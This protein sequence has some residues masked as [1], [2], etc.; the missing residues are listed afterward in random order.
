MRF[1]MVA[2]MLTAVIGFAT[3][4]P[5]LAQKT[6]EDAVKGVVRAE[7]EAFYARN[8]EAWQGAWLHDPSVTRTLIAY[9]STTSQKGWDSIAGPIV[10]SITANPQ[11]VPIELAL[12]NLAIRREG[13]LAYVEYDQI[14]TLPQ[15]AGLNKAISRAARPGEVAR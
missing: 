12:E 11:P 6:D 9:G 14:L 13:H 2:V 8:L 15:V 10:K 4:K 5:V 7:T 3:A 1:G